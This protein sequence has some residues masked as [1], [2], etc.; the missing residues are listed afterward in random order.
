MVHGSFVFGMDHDGEEIFDRTVDWAVSKGIETATFH[1]LT[2]YP[3]TALYAR[4]VRAGR[5]LTTNWDLFD[6]RHAVFSPARMR[7]ETLEAGYYRAYKKFYAFRRIFEAASTKKDLTKRAR[8]LAYSLG[9]KK[10]EPF[11]NIVIRMGLLPRMRPLLEGLLDA[12]GLGNETETVPF[13]K[14]YNHA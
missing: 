12:T 5:M 7:P 6:T 1:I 3:G 4:M 11:W 13:E 2:P 8:H 9:W 14:G 10:L